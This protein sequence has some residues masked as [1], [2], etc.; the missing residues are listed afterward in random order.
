MACTCGDVAARPLLNVEASEA[1]VT[2]RPPSSG[3]GCSMSSTVLVDN[4]KKTI[5]ML[6]GS[7][8]KAVVAILAALWLSAAGAALAESRLDSEKA[9]SLASRLGISATRLWLNHGGLHIPPSELSPEEQRE[10]IENALKRYEAVR[11][12]YA[13]LSTATSASQVATG[14][15]IGGAILLGGPVVPLTIIGTA[16]HIYF[17]LLNAKVEKDGREHATSLLAEVADDLIQE[18]GVTDFNALADNPTLLRDTV[19]QSGLI[20][21]DTKR[22]A[23]ESGDQDIVNMAADVIQRAAMATDEATLTALAKTDKKGTDLDAEF[24]KFIQAAY[25]SNKQIAKRLEDQS[26]STKGVAEGLKA[27]SEDVSTMGEQIQRL[28]RNQ[29]LVADFMFS[30]LPPGEKAKALRS[31]LMDDRIRCPKDEAD[32]NRVEV[33]A[34]MIRRYDAEA[35]VVEKVKDAGKVLAGINDIRTIA[36]NLGIDLGE[37]GNWA[38]GMVSGV[39]EASIGVMTAS[40]PLGVIASFTGIFGGIFGKKDPGAERFR[41]NVNKKTGRRVGGPAEDL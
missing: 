25:N 24:G 6:Q 28:G 13:G 31:G 23:L 18:A 5:L 30:G 14:G 1:K 2:E 35:D 33:K 17:D 34:A 3:E 7:A 16:S 26:R 27:L 19:I 29:D 9:A 15:L 20:L 41:K 22:R 40:N 39:F 11:N 8:T 32:C 37:I 10:R 36:S 38:I 4:V 21:E 12:G